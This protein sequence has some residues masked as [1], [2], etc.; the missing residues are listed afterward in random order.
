MVAAN[1][2]D[3]ALV[4]GI[5]RYIGLRD[6]AGNPSVLLGPVTDAKS[7]FSWL[8]DPLGG[9]L[10]QANIELIH[11]GQFA[12][13]SDPG[14]SGPAYQAVIA[15]LKKIMDRTKDVQGRRLYVY[16]SG[17]GFAPDV[18]RGALFT[19]ECE[20]PSYP[21]VYATGWLNWFRAQQRF[22]EFVLW[23]DCCFD[24]M[25]SV[26]VEAPPV[27]TTPLVG[28][29]GPRFIGLAAQT[30]MRALECPIPQ[31]R[32]EVHGVFT[33]TLLTGLRGAAVDKAT[34]LVT[35]ESLRAYLLNAM[36][37]FIPADR[38]TAREISTAP[39]V[40][41][42]PPA[43]GV[44]F[45]TQRVA[46]KFNVRL[47]VPAPDGDH[48]TVWSGM[49]PQIISTA[50]VTGGAANVSLEPGVYAAEAASQALRAGFEVTA[51]AKI[52]ELRE[53]SPPFDPAKANKVFTL[54]V[55]AVNSVVDAQTTALGAALTLV[56][57]Q[58]NRITS[59]FGLIAG[60]YACGIYKVIV[61][62]GSEI[63][64]KSESIILLDHDIE[65]LKIAAPILPSAAPIADL[66]PTH[67]HH[68]EA[69]ASLTLPQAAVA[70]PPPPIP[71]PSPG[72]ES[73]DIEPPS[74][75]AE[76][77]REAR[78][79][80]G[81]AIGMLA[82]F[83]TGQQPT[84]ND[85]SLFP[86]P[87]EGVSILDD[88]GQVIIDLSTVPYRQT[89]DPVASF[90]T[91][92]SPG[93]YLLRQ[94]FDNGAILDRPIVATRDWQT[95]VFI[96]RASRDV[97]P[98]S[99]TAPRLRSMGSVSLLMARPGASALDL[100]ALSATDAE[101]EGWGFALRDRRKISSVDAHQ[102]LTGKA[103]NPIAGIIGAHLALLGEQASPDGAKPNRDWLNEVIANLRALVGRDHPDVEALSL[104]CPLAASRATLISAPP[105]YLRSWEVM[106]E[107]MSDHAGD[108]SGLFPPNAWWKDWHRAFDP[109]Y[110]VWVRG[111][112][113]PS[114][115]ESTRTPVTAL[116]T[117]RG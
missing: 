10:D 101:I 106:S 78:G 35:G 82:R 31:D 102:L 104:L 96:R 64:N 54:N 56:D 33:W 68:L 115:L 24:S 67:E 52:V 14:T 75:A 66:T 65:G 112:R 83:W 72:L 27:R 98:K 79:G 86:N 32:N 5:S 95:N 42:D 111:R 6:E 107:A 90:A 61:Q 57:S 17:H 9:G 94:A 62:F 85:A 37:D 39:N 26:P 46:P 100:N 29:A 36:K 108:P 84:I 25:D 110:M 12:A 48:V 73:L 16:M 76:G 74:G 7:I 19:A 105:M 51:E 44:V 20:D 2:S 97:G 40:L 92:V 70:A 103:D 81:S 80:G 11:S 50:T 22:K 63:A 60:G 88:Q 117:I 21:N 71:L 87:F 77:A 43:P 30:G 69:A 8:V 15:A 4:V 59:S 23:M 53:H 34:N 58:F 47:N 18:D 41:S 13:S 1:P 113:P 28:P 3:R 45:G 91:N 38:R 114:G 55:S 116:E 49:P 109:L 93:V 99:E 89:A